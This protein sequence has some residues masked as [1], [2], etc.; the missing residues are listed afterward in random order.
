MEAFLSH[1]VIAVV[2]LLGA[3]V[4][5]HELGHFLAGRWCGIAVEV[6][7][8][9]FGPVLLS[10]KRGL[11]EYR[12]S[13]VPLGGYVKF[14]GAVKSEPVPSAVVGQEFY[15]AS[16]LRRMFTVAAG[17][18]ANFLLAALAFAVL[19]RTG[20][21]HPP[22]VVGD[23]LPGSAAEMAGVFPGDKL[24]AIDGIEVRRWRD[25]ESAIS[26]SA[27]REMTWRVQRGPASINLQVTP[28]EVEVENILGR[29]T[30]IGRAGVSLGIVP[31]VISVISRD[32]IAAK[33]GLR[34]GDKVLA[35]GCP[36][37]DEER[38]VAGFGDF[39]LQLR[40]LVEQCPSGVT[41]RTSRSGAERVTTMNFPQG[42][43][44]DGGP[45]AL[46]NFAKVREHARRS[47]IE[48]AQLVVDSEKLTPPFQAGDR[49][50]SYGGKEI[51]GI[52]GL[53]D[54]ILQ[55]QDREIKITVDRNFERLDLDVSL[56]GVDTQQAKG[57]VVVYTLPVQ[58]QGGP[59]EPQP[60]I[61]QY[62]QWHLALQ[63]GF[64]E[65]WR[66]VVMLSNALL[67]LMSGEIPLK[68]LGG[69]IMIAKVAGDSAKVGWQAFLSSLALISVNLGL[70]NL[71]PIPI[72][73]GGQMVLFSIEAILRRPLGE[74]ALE[75]FQRLGFV[76]VAALVILATYNDFSR[77]WKSMLA[78][79]VG[80]GG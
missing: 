37:P 30:R 76:L 1:P 24:L 18:A 12:L 63:Y 29:K 69:P 6:F 51:S 62:P 53:R 39:I 20:I 61:E 59:E 45:G 25:L 70:V 52:F 50:L 48:D 7:S 34:N 44:A 19:G 66:Q 49:L 31:S 78:A 68:A 38:P 16:Y 67:H 79:L 8:I 43:Q 13:A 41:V 36:G 56:K 75:A 73:D 10:F 46:S 9:G 21:P 65:C 60:V 4:F 42:W 77:F 28:A 72:L 57:K 47:G 58:L 55:N 71:V 15:R 5:V 17:P 32:S 40:K 2:I 3:L 11:T 35:I 22:A 54:L 74:R 27:S 33:A 80:E 23:V 14:Y 64:A 26:K